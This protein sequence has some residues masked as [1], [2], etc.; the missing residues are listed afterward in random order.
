MAVAVEAAV[1]MAGVLVV[2]A[3]AAAVVV[4]S[5]ALAFLAQ[6][7]LQEGIIPLMRSLSHAKY[8]SL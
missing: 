7:L 4:A 3:V 1:L 2:V 8:Y 5:F 6:R